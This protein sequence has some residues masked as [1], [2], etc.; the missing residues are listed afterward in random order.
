VLVYLTYSIGFEK[1]KINFTFSIK[2]GL[3]DRWFGCKVVSM[4]R[5]DQSARDII[6]YFNEDPIDL[7]TDLPKND[8]WKKYFEFT[9]ILVKDQSTLYHIHGGKLK[10][11]GIMTS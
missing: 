3:G 2:L 4:V 5:A 11:Y 10:V 1:Q 9:Q 8:G 7:T 6:T